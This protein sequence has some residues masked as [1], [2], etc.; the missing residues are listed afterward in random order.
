M[1]T[2]VNRSIVLGAIYSF[3]LF[4]VL[5]GMFF[6]A[7]PLQDWTLLWEQ[8]LFELPFVLIAPVVSLVV[9][10]GCGMIVGLV[11]RK[12]LSI[13]VQSVEALNRGTNFEVDKQINMTEIASLQLKLKEVQQYIN[14][15]T[16]RTQRLVDERVEDQEKQIEQ[17][18]SEERN[19]L[20]RELHDSV[21]QE[22]FAASMMVSAMNESTM[23]KSEMLTKQLKQ[24]EAIIQQAQLEMRALLLHLRPVALKNKS[25]TEGVKQLLEE[26]QQK[27]PL[28]INWKME[29]VQLS[30]GVEDHLFRILQESIS[31]TLR[32]AK[33]TTLDVWLVERDHFVILRVT[34][35]GVGFD[36]EENSAGSYGL[37]NMKER[38]AE[39]GANFRMISIPNEGTRLEVR[40]PIIDIEGERID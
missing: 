19:R 31:N 36:M 16:K 35:D 30:K 17:V 23:D 5:G 29:Q 40:V 20:A 33:A 1:K 8:T 39:V 21:S 2:V 27:V 25:I 38:A 32:H 22:L 11:S 12:Q 37:T 24:I 28:E 13:V 6:L 3:C 7:F 18:V 26:L 10:A 4:L 14:E 15:Q 34:D 9:G